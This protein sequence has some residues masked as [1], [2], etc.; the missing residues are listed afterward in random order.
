MGFLYVGSLHSNRGNLVQ[1]K[2]IGSRQILCHGTNRLAT[3]EK[4]D[5]VNWIE[6]P[7]EFGLI[8]FS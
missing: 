4:E 6:N 5:N 1:V 3:Y 2:K 8:L 7:D